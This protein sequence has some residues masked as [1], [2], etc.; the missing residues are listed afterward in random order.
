MSKEELMNDPQRDLRIQQFEDYVKRIFEVCKKHLGQSKYQDGYPALILNTDCDDI[1]GGYYCH[2]L[3]ELE[4][5]YQGFDDTKYCAE[6]Y[7]Q[8]VYHEFIHYHQSPHWFKR[9]YKHHGHDY[10]SHPYEV[11]AYKRESEILNLI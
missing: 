1:M 11:E 10:L 6:Y 8:L 4:I 5:N 7:A 2:D 9:Y 3:N